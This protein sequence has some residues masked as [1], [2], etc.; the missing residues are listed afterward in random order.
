MKNLATPSELYPAYI[1]SP[2]S[3]TDLQR[4]ARFEAVARFCIWLH[5]NPLNGTHYLPF[6]PIVH[7]HALAELHELPSTIDYWWPHNK[8]MIAALRRVI[9]LCIDG[10]RESIGM[11]K[12]FDYILQAKT[13]SFLPVYET[14]LPSEPYIVPVQPEGWNWLDR[15]LWKAPPSGP[16]AQPAPTSDTPECSPS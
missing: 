9:I 1:M 11:S 4:Q 15:D 5:T 2:Y 12:E 3:G 16:T 8:G 13:I 7:N 14:A 6:S 10:Y